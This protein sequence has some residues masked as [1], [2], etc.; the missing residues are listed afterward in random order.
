MKCT[1][2]RSWALAVGMVVLAVTAVGTA[3]AAEKKTL[4]IG[5][6][7]SDT[8]TFDPARMA[9]YSPPLTMGAAYDTLVTMKSADYVTIR[10]ALSTSWELSADGAAWIFHLR[11]GVKFASGNPLTA[12]DVKFSFDRLVNLK[13]QPAEY[14]ENVKSTEVIDPLTVKVNM[15]D[16]NQPLLSL[17]VAPAFS[18]TDSKLLKAQGGVSGPEAEKKDT[19]VEWINQ[20]SA[21]SGAYKLVR[22]TRNSEIVLERNPHYWRG[23]PPF[24]RVIIRHIGDSAA[25]LLAIKRGDIDVAFN[26]TPDQLETLNDNPDV[27][28]VE[29]LSLDYMY[30][31]LT[32]EPDY[33]K[34]LANKACR[35]AVTHAIDF[36]GISKGLLGG[37]STRPA[38]FIPVGLPGSSEET[39]KKY[40]YVQ[41]LAKAKDLLKKCGR[42]D[43]F[44]FE[45]NYAKA[46]IAG[47]SYDIVAQ[48]LE[49]DLS[50]VG[51]KA[52]LTPLNQ[53]SL[54]DRYKGGKS[55][56]VLTFWNPDAPESYLWSQASVH[57]VAD[58]VRWKA[59]QS[60]KDL[61][62]Q[63]AGER[64]QMKQ[65]AL[66]QKY[67]EILVDQANYII[68]F[69]PIY[70]WATRKEIMGY[71]PTAAGWHVDLFNVKPSE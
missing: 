22:W 55:T 66:Y 8:R 68:L 56:A 10:P 35:Q 60:V 3:T 32:S 21:G 62:F 49:S 13:D 64:D 61:V 46:A 71:E 28:N 40:R 6:D 58:R 39:A 9:Q 11:D 44:S 1:W 43:G 33:N 70:R 20:N 18:I 53:V 14:A 31:T 57:R 45:L 19:V 23:T 4:V 5:I 67:T 12:E 16:M 63:T 54:R 26:L 59:P 41:D 50:R 29:L 27:R 38:T 2:G 65:D 15:V 47:T 25:Q 30:M 7:I 17:L 51:I 42:P 34:A 52:E 36:D 24:E 37:Y 69:Q 48:K